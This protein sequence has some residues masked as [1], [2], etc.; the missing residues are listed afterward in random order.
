M[1]QAQTTSGRAMHGKAHTPDPD[2]AYL[3][4]EKSGHLPEYEEPEKYLRELEM[5]LK[6]P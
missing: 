5:L 4:F 1:M 6:Q 2:P 3:T